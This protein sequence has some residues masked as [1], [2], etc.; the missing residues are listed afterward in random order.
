M[1]KS[2]ERIYYIITGALIAALY[3]GLTF[4]SNVFNLAFGPVQ[5][6]ISEV[7]T[8][9]PVFT[10]AAIPGVAVGCF[11][12][13][14]ASFNPLDMIFGTSATVVAA[15]LTYF[16]RKIKFKGIPLLSMLPPVI[17]NALVIG[18]ELAIFYLPKGNLLWGF[19]ISA[20]QVGLGEFA[21]CVVLGIPFYLV[22]E[23]NGIF[24]RKPEKGD[25]L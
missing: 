22:I 14:I 19:A 2:R 16:F 7:L 18:L 23:K 24:K 3:V 17:I 5:F 13:N 8:I 1:S 4:L 6:R 12:A 11:I 9:L 15:L 25:K 10:S 20:L 21:V